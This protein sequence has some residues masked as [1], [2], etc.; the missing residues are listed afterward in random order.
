MYIRVKGQKQPKKALRQ[1]RDS[2][3]CCHLM[4][5]CQC[6]RL[7]SL[8]TSPTMLQI[9]QADVAHIFYVFISLGKCT[10]LTHLFQSCKTSRDYSMYSVGFS[11][12]VFLLNEVITAKL[13]RPGLKTFSHAGLGCI[14]SPALSLDVD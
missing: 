11:C 4:V 14:T 2:K 10:F 5:L 8:L 12:E 9:F 7:S 3:C 1:K 6:C 13:P